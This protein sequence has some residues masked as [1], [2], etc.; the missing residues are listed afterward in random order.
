MTRFSIFALGLM[1]CTN[2]GPSGGPDNGQ[3]QTDGGTVVSDVRYAVDGWDTAKSS[4]V[5]NE[6]F[7]AGATL[8][9]DGS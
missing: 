6:N 3:T 5:G 2:N 7:D 9:P 1:A 8:V 4:P